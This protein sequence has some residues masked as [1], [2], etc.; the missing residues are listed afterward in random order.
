[1]WILYTEAGTVTLPERKIEEL[2]TLVDIP[3]TQRRMVQ[4]DLEHLE[5]K[6]LSVHLAVAGAVAKLFY[7]QRTLNQGGVERVWI[8]LAFNR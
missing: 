5:G 6:L 8:P 3:V 1:M 7:I 4:K 2:L